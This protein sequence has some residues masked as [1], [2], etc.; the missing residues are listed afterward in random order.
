MTSEQTRQWSGM[1]LWL[2]QQH[3][4]SYWAH[5]A[6]QRVVGA[7]LGANYQTALTELTAYET[8]TSG[9]TVGGTISTA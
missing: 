1:P 8:T 5:V 4:Q 3:T 9:S 7:R 6:L 2:L